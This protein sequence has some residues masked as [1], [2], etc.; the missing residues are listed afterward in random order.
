MGSREEGR[1]FGDKDRHLVLNDEIS[2]GVRR[3]GY[4]AEDEEMGYIPFVK[5][6]WTDGIII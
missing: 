3:E 1:A 2:R 4:T 5:A 6:F